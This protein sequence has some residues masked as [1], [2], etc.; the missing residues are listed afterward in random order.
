MKLYDAW[1][2]LKQ[3]LEKQSKIDGLHP[4]PYSVTLDKIEELEEKHE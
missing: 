2:E 1:E 3:W 4:N